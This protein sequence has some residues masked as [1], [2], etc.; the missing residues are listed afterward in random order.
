MEIQSRIRDLAILF[1]LFGA[2][3]SSHA[4]ASEAESPARSRFWD[5]VQNLVLSC[6]VEPVKV[7]DGRKIT[8]PLRSS[9]DEVQVSG[10][11]ARLFVDGRWYTAVLTDSAESDGGDLNDIRVE[12]EKGN[13]VAELHNVPAFGDVL[14]GLAGGQA[15]VQEVNVPQ[16]EVQ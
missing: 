7:A 13:V 1:S 6:A 4:L 3:F 8:G 12:D 11:E 14:L 5:Q 16:I 15:K 10:N 2:A 9:C